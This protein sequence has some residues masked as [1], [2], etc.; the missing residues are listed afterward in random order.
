MRPVTCLAV[1]TSQGHRGGGR[2]P[3]PPPPKAGSETEPCPGPPAC[4]WEAGPTLLPGFPGPSRRGQELAP[5]AGA[6]GE[7]SHWEELNISLA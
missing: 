6:R 3:D 2:Q 1:L 7:E 5:E 4:A